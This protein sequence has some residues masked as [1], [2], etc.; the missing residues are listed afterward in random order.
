MRLCSA[1]VR[2]LGLEDGR[3]VELVTGP[4]AGNGYRLQQ[5]TSVGILNLNSR[6]THPAKAH[7]EVR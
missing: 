6:P 2:S 7:R 3:I 1:R 4:D 5:G